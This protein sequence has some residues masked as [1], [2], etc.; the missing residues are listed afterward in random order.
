MA[1]EAVIQF[2]LLLFGIVFKLFNL[3]PLRDKTVMLA[4]FG[5]NIEY[6]IGEVKNQTSS[7]IFILK[8]P[9]C[10]KQFEAVSQKNITDFTPVSLFS[11]IRGIYHLATARYVFVDNYHVVLAACNFRPS[12]RC[13]QVWH[14]NGAV[15]YFGFRDKTIKNRP[16]S[17]HKRFKKV[18]SRFHHITVSSDEMAYIF[19]EA[20]GADDSRI[21]KTGVPRTDFFYNMDKIEA[22]AEKIRSALPILKDKKAL[23]Y[24]PTFRDNQFD[25]D[26]IQLDID[27]MRK[28]L[29]GE[30]HLLLKLHPAVKLSGFNNSEFV[31]D[32]SGKYEINS[33]LAA[34][35]VLITD[36]SSIPF[37]FSILN[38][39]MIFFPYDLKEYEESRGIWFNY[40]TYM[41]GPVAYQ[42][43]DIITA[44]EENDFDLEKIASFN[45]QWN[46]YSSGQASEKLIEYIYSM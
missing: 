20:F 46:K 24:A 43:A 36:Y 3:L 44:L 5:D 34:A 28:K 41:P 22:E 32:V 23:L 37:E 11:F 42:T 18:Y 4:S 31:T 21:L 26:K 29:D 45:K 14:A 13:T 35:D 7:E 9:R 17:A 10:K 25:T 40:E 16:D 39:P 12:V 38:K 8:E 6:V 19:K 1:K 15:K 27:L 2:F 30:Y 33:L